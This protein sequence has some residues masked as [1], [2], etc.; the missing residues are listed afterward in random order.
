[1]S[2]GRKATALKTLREGSDQE[3]LQPQDQRRGWGVGEMLL[4]DIDCGGRNRDLYNE[5]MQCRCGNR[6]PCDIGLPRGFAARFA[7]FQAQRRHRGAVLAI[8]HGGSSLGHVLQAGRAGIGRDGLLRQQHEAEGAG[9]EPFAEVA[10]ETHVV[11]GTVVDLRTQVAA[12]RCG[13]R[14]H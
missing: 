6:R 7:M 3:T 10:G 2:G 13:T 14:L 5:V 9:G 8:R 11:M 1:M 4:P 12:S